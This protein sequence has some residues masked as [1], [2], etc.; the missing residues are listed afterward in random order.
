[1]RTLLRVESVVKTFPGLTALDGVS[2]SVDSGEILAVIGHNGSGKS[3]LVKILAGVYSRD[4][5]QVTLS[6]PEEEGE[7]VTEMHFIHQD[8]ALI[9]ELTAVENLYLTKG[10]LAPNK[11][12]AQRAR[13]SELI[14]HFGEVFD[15]DIPVKQLTPGQRAIV[16]IARAL[17]GWDHPRNVIVLDEPTESLHKSEV[18]VLFQAVR[19]LAADG[20]GVIFISHRLDE[21]LELADRVAVLRDGKKVADEPTTSLDHGRLVELITGS[22]VAELA[23]SKPPTAAGDPVLAVTGLRGGGI[24]RL[25]LT[26]RAGEIVGIAGVLGS[27]REALPT[28]LFGATSA[29]A[30]TFEVSATAY[31]H[32]SPA[33]SIRRGIAY[34]PADRF[35]FGSVRAFTAR[36]NM[37]LPELRSLRTRTG[38]INRARERAEASRLID[39][40]QVRP[41]RPEQ[42]F[43][44]FSGGNQQKIMFAK[45]LRNRPSLLLLEEPTQ[46][47]DIGA[48]AAIYQAIE[49]AAAAGAAVLV[50]SS[51][52]KELLR[53]CQRVIVLR[54][55]LQA[56]ELSGE[57][58][59]EHRLVLA[60]YGLKD[61]GGAA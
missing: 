35:R 58:L 23:E 9:P 43:G 3:T 49:A 25:D 34:V 51:D 39:E 52:A 54:D 28:L 19:Q 2:L 30:E 15:V 55:G 45:W 42:M 11:L 33:E 59:T 8:L 53:L 4:A 47:V 13:T 6:S 12:A 50:C 46:G 14:G 18:D 44:A 5:G 61:M 29:T 57:I 24:E 20:A 7:E 56:E 38:A 41:P 21:V 60:G 17:D 10:R 31:D 32:R 27:G 16:A 37:T 36:E 22:S 1:V 48:K 40:F 26:V